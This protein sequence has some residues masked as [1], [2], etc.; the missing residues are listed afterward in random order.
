ME[1]TKEMS[2]VT[3]MSQSDVVRILLTD[4]QSSHT[5]HEVAIPIRY[6][7]LI[8]ALSDLLEDFELREAGLPLLNVTVSQ[9]RLIE[10]QLEKLYSI[11]H[12]DPHDTH[13]RE[14][15]IEEYEQLDAQG[16]I[17]VVHALDYADIPLL[18]EL[19]CDVVKQ[20][21]LERFSVEQMS[22]LPREM[23]KRILLHKILC[24]G[25][26]MFAKEVTHIKHESIVSSVCV[27]KD[28][29]IV[30]GYRDGTVRVWDIRAIELAVCTG[31]EFELG[32]SLCNKRWH[33]CL[34]F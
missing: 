13:S 28:G 16:L 21:D 23:D 18:L 29:K 11:V 19:A 1:R 7:K 9:W 2:S 27:T 8:G 31:H 17:E 12:D 24:L 20:S 15:I 4:S 5:I 33:Y 14:A 22:S 25:G 32:S 34:R 3:E 6:A 10:S 26:P 30:S